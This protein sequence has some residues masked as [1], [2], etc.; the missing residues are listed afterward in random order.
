LIAIGPIV[1]PSW[2]NVNPMDEENPKLNALTCVFAVAVGATILTPVTLEYSATRWYVCAG[3][4]LLAV[5][6]MLLRRRIAAQEIAKQ[7]RDPKGCQATS[8]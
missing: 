8:C 7:T 6:S 1:G 4:G 2:A 5:G 3:C